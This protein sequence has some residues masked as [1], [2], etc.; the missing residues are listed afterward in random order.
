MLKFR[1]FK[2]ARQGFPFFLILSL[3]ILIF[4]STILILANLKISRKREEL[5]LE[6]E[7]LK[8]KIESLKKEREN[9]ESKIF[10][11]ESED[12]I[13][14]TAREELNLKKEEEKV[15]AFPILKE[16]E[17]EPESEEEKNF[18]QKFLEKINIK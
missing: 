14:K 10:Q 2:R 7:T 3:G 1:K 6:K 12:F 4:L 17:E 11:A 8:N 9:L 18:L 16:G 15:V 13:E 5:D